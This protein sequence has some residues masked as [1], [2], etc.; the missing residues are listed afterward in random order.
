MEEKKKNRL[1]ISLM[2]DLD[3]LEET[4]PMS[5]ASWKRQLFWRKSVEGKNLKFCLKE[6]VRFMVK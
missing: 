3:S 1:W 4:R 2:S 6:G 5:Q